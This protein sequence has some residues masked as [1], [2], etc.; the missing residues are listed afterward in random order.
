MLV[1]P[2]NPTQGLCYSTVDSNGNPLPNGSAATPANCNRA[3][4][5]Y[6]SWACLQS[7]SNPFCNGNPQPA[8]IAAVR[9]YT[10]R[11]GVSINLEQ[12]ISETI[13]VFAR[14]GWADGTREP[15]DFT[16]ID[17]TLAGLSGEA[18]SQVSTGSTDIH[19]GSVA[20]AWNALPE[21]SA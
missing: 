1:D 5:T 21:P 19:I 18:S 14:G 9:T 20:K 16:D 8:D 4:A 17:R 2:A 3:S 7:P 10:S 12:Q 13:G 11:P 6:L 15:W